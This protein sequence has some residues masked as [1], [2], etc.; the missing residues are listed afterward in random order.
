MTYADSA[1]VQVGQLQAQWLTDQ[2]SHATKVE[3]LEAKMATQE[4]KASWRVL[5]RRQHPFAPEIIR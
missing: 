5:L 1:A 4:R 2:Q 3:K